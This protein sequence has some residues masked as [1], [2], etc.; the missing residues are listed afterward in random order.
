MD[1][2]D[3]VAAADRAALHLL[4]GPVSYAPSVGPPVDV[5]GIFD[6]TFVTASAGEAGVATYTPAVFLRLSDLPSDPAGEEVRIT[7]KG[8]EYRSWRAQKDGQGGVV[9]L[10][11]RV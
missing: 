3:H 4:G 11:H 10:L 9:I 2:A 8:I 6:P 1:F 7:V 5:V